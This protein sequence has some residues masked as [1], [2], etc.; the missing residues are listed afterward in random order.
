MKGPYN[1]SEAYEFGI[2]I[3]HQDTRLNWL[4]I[5]KIPDGRFQKIINDKHEDIQ[6]ATFLAEDPEK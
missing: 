6:L 5:S 1:F 2:V 3:K 4:K